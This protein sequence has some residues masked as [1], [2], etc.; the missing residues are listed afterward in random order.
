MFLFAAYITYHLIR[1][2]CEYQEK[3]RP[4]FEKNSFESCTDQIRRFM[5]AASP[6]MDVTTIELKQRAHEL[7]PELVTGLERG[8]NGE[9]LAEEW[10]LGIVFIASACANQSGT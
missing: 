1:A 4:R 3:P 10:Y 8:S 6:L 7:M 2:T 5:K 9:N